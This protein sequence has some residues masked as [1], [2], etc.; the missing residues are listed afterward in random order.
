MV[1]LLDIA[2][3]TEKVTVGGKTLVVYGISAK[4]LVSLIA[5][6]PEIKRLMAGKEVDVASLMSM[7]GD[8]ISAIIAA[9]IGFPGDEKQEEAAARLSLEVQADILTAIIKVTLPNGIGPFVEKLTALGAVAGAASAKVP[10]MKSPKSS[11]N[12]PSADKMRPGSGTPRRG[13]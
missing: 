8:A 13:N 4:G 11:S 12:S 7:G 3:L 10:A 6:F 1:G 9:G 5:S 2:P